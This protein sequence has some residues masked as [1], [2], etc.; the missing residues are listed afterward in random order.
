MTLSPKTIKVVIIATIV[1]M[2]E[3]IGF[4][5]FQAFKGIPLEEPTSPVTLKESK[6]IGVLHFRQ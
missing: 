5:L 2:T 6:K 4:N 3:I 1:T